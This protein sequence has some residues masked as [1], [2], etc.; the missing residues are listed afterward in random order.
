VCLPRYCVNARLTAWIHAQCA[1][2]AACYCALRGTTRVCG[3]ASAH[4][5]GTSCTQHAM[6]TL[7]MYV[8]T[9]L[10]T[11]SLPIEGACVP[12]R[13]FR[14]ERVKRPQIATN[15]YQTPLAKYTL[16]GVTYSL[17]ER[18]DGRYDGSL[19]SL[20]YVARAASG[21]RRHPTSDVRDVGGGNH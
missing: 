9:M 17:S 15:A 7:T 13:L 1:L 5:H 21:S 6:H 4:T 20:A 16:R 19:G 11:V 12:G 3:V 14:L 10:S 2:H 18:S 8:L